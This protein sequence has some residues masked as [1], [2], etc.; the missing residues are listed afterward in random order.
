MCT[1]TFIINNLSA[2]RIIVVFVIDNFFRFIRYKINLKFMHFADNSVYGT[3]DPDRERLYKVRP[4]ILLQ[5]K[6]PRVSFAKKRIWIDEQLMLHKGNLYFKQ[7]I[8][9]KRATLGIKFFN[10]CDETGYLFMWGRT[11][12]MMTKNIRMWEKADK[13]LWG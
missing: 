12:L 13:L 3:N 2:V 11:S 4:L 1:A 5:W 9:N 10:L 6:V 7:Y 8:P